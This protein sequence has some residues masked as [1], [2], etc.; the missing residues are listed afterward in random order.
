MNVELEAQ[1]ARI[2]SREPTVRAWVHHDPDRVREEAAIAPHGLLHSFT[3]GVKDIFDTADMPTTYGSSIYEGYQPPADAAAVALARAEGAV[4]M[5]KTV[6]TEMAFLTP[7]PTTNPYDPTR[8]PGGSSSGS[9]AAVADGMVRVAL[10]TQT[11]GSVIRPASFCG[12]VGFKPSHGLLPISGVHL[13]A[14]TLDTV[15][16]FARTVDDVIVLHRALTGRVVDELNDPPRIGL[17]E[18]HQWES[19]GDSARHA[20]TA[21]AKRAADCGATGVGV[22]PIGHS[23]DLDRAQVAIMAYEGARSLSHDRLRNAGRLSPELMAFLRRGTE[24]SADEYDAAL[25]L[26]E[27]GRDQMNRVFETVDVLLTPAAPDEAPLGIDGTGDPRCNRM[28]TLLGLPC[29]TVPGHRG[30][31]GLPVGVQVVAR[32]GDDSTALA[33]ARW[34]SRLLPKPSPPT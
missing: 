11:A 18:S 29:V 12:V 6:T 19:I 33:V 28:W 25:R 21:A 16:T 31:T 15:G 7:G 23:H 5:G 32:R 4:L 30:A 26:T 2:K 27:V 10:G 13:F 9:A 20:V 3:L 17:Y 34:L 22:A 1:L 14:P 8:T 24:L